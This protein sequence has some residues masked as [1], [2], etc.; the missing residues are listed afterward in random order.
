LFLNHYDFKDVEY[1]DSTTEMY[2]YVRINF[3][4]FYKAYNPIREKQQTVPTKSGTPMK[5]VILI[6]MH[7]PYR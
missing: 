6:K 4:V 1:N 2:E 5:L 7:D 3:T